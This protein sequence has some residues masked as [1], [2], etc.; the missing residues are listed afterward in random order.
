MKKSFTLIELLVVIA[1]IAILAGM[2]LPALNQARERAYTTQCTANMKQ[3]GSAYSFYASDNH[4][5]AVVSMWQ[6]CFFKSRYLPLPS[7]KCPS[8]TYTGFW[9]DAYKLAKA[10]NWSESDWASNSGVC[11]YGINGTFA[12]SKPDGS[13]PVKMS[14]FKQASKT[15]LFVDS[16]RANRLNECGWNNVNWYYDSPGN[17]PTLWPAHQAKTTANG[18]YADGHTETGR[19]AGMGE[20]ASKSLYALKGGPFYTNPNNSKDVAGRWHRHDGWAPW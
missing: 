8:R 5:Y 20:E 9:S 16:I 1:I 14:M 13:R 11:D 10:A 19:G 12:Q 15:I 2:L 7:L 3:I 6:Y 18:I 4:D 17:G